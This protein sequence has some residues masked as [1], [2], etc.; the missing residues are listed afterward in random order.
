MG[1]RFGWLVCA[2]ALLWGGCPTDGDDD[3]DV[4]GAPN[5]H[6]T[7]ES[8]EFNPLAAGQSASF[9]VTLANTGDATLTV[10]DLRIEGDDG[11]SIDDG[12]TERLLEPDASTQLDV[13]CEPTGDGE[14]AAELVVTSDDPDE[15]EVRVVLGCTGM[16]AVI[17]VDPV[18]IDFGDVGVG[19]EVEVDVTIS[20]VG[21]VAFV[22]QEVVFAPTSD[23]MLVSYYWQTGYELEPGESATV[24]LYY[25]P[26][27]EIP[28]TGYLTLYTNMPDSPTVTI[29]AV[30]NGVL[31]AEVTDEVEQVAND[32]TDIL[33]VIN[34]TASMADD[35]AALQN[36]GG[37]FFDIL[38][39]LDIDW[40]VSVITS[41]DPGLQGAV[42]IITPTAPDA[43][44]AFLDAVSVPTTGTDE[45]GLASS[46][47]A[48]TP[49]LAAPG[50]ANDGFLRE[51]AGL[52]VIYVD[53]EDDASPDPV[54]DYV[55][56]LQ[57][58]KVNPGHVVLSALVDPADA[59]RYLQAVS[60]TG[61]ILESLHGPDWV[62]LL[63]SLAGICQSHQDT[64][65]LSQD[66][67][68]ETMSVWINGIPVYVGWYYDAVINAVVFDPDYVPDTGDI[69]TITYNPT[70]TC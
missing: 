53:D 7:P 33:W 15:P 44:A 69:V 64:F 34:D 49:P 14:L 41:S 65:E 10:E 26:R 50:G 17:E 5:I 30:G 23:E 68:E 25:E 27:D 35:V 28:D 48:L 31:G 51:D 59:T 46:A 2:G 57:S 8:I 52:R 63:S 4:A 1:L 24:T 37:A 22:L 56:T 42:P 70:A 12:E 66:P 9:P 61:G 45:T 55:T 16:S 11:F 19:C 32:Q 13:A 18:D 38:T 43:T 58:L 36:V 3:D 40:H 54:A 47:E 20:S 29:T 60:D 67:V 39:V 21:S 62:S 6:V